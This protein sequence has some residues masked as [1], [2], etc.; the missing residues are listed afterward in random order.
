MG[1]NKA[2]DLSQLLAC[3]CH[4][5]DLQLLPFIRCIVLLFCQAARGG[6]L[7]WFLLAPFALTF[8]WKAKEATSEINKG[9]LGAEESYCAVFPVKFTEQLAQID[10]LL[11]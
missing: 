9:L 7:N 6:E 4:L 2:Y 3:L 10:L 5:F 11:I 1:T 8:P